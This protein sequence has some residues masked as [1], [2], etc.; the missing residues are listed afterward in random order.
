[1]MKPKLKP[2]HPQRLRDA[3]SRLNKYIEAN[4]DHWEKVFARLRSLPSENG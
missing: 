3:E 2:K 1:M 4:K